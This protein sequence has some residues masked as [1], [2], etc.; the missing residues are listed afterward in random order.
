MKFW[1]WKK[2]WKVSKSAKKRGRHSKEKIVTK[3]TKDTIIDLEDMED[4]EDTKTKWRDFEVE[5]LIA[6]WRKMDE[7]FA[8][9][10]NKKTNFFPMTL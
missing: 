9:A 5:Y 7:E 3:K 8:R 10:T 1:R 2:K 4:V 6:L